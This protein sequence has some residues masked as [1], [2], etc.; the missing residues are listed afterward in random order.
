MPDLKEHQ[1]RPQLLPKQQQREDHGSQRKSSCSSHSLHSI[2]LTQIARTV[3]QRQVEDDDATISKTNSPDRCRPPTRRLTLTPPHE[4]STTEREINYKQ[5]QQICQ[6]ASVVASKGDERSAI[7]L[8][9]D[10]LTMLQR[11]IQLISHHLH[12]SVSAKKTP[13]SQFDKTTMYIVLREEWSEVAAYIAHVQTMMAV[14]YERLGRYTK[15]LNCCI[16]ARDVCKRNAEF[17][18]GRGQHGQTTAAFSA[19][20]K[21]HMIRMEHM[22]MKIEQ[23]KISYARRRQ[24]YS[25]VVHNYE[26]ITTE[27]CDSRTKTKLYIDARTKIDTLLALQQDHL[28]GIHPDV[29]DSKALLA[30]LLLKGSNFNGSE[31]NILEA[32]S[33]SEIALGKVHPRT[34]A[35]YEVAAEIYGSVQS[36]DKVVKAIRMYD[37]AIESFK[38]SHGDHV[39]KIMSLMR[40]AGRMYMQ[41]GKYDTANKRL[42]GAIQ[43]FRSEISRIHNQVDEIPFLEF[44]IWTDLADCYEKKGDVKSQTSAL[45]NAL[46]IQR[47]L[48]C[49]SMSQ[50]VSGRN[51]L[52][53]TSAAIID[54][55]KRIGKCHAD[56]KL[57][58]T[59]C[60]HLEEALSLLRTEYAEA[61]KKAKVIT[62]SQSVNLSTLDD[63]VA[64]VLY[65]LADVRKRNKEYSKAILLYEECL[66]MRMK[67]IHERQR[68]SRGGWESVLSSSADKLNHLHCAIT[69]A[70]IGSIEI[71]QGKYERSF[72]TINRAIQYARCCDLPD[73]HPVLTSLWEDRK[74]A[75]SMMRNKKT[76]VKKDCSS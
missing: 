48:Q 70:N 31:R 44:D 49:R 76:S 41:I 66:K 57:Y 22:I 17:G 60:I 9:Q 55:L 75:A 5:V 11:G 28:G 24:L 8:Y 73:S 30:K 45:C 39:S 33:I 18:H 36:G 71:I 53:G 46:E 56:Q 14:L 58:I 10:C 64:S 16:E 61:T 15:A 37:Q 54:T 63:R 52:V 25:E 6:Q 38:E 23:S 20:A 59:S 43:Y 72:K 42:D 32:I 7:R 29:A 68:H 21:D 2:P 4:R 26:K 74:V 67:R 34:A 65:C 19:E 69:L 51:S 13:Q 1:Q 50:N 47:R 3:E 35:K 27:N 62:E 40:Q 12:D